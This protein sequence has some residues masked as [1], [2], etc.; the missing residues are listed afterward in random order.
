MEK[1]IIISYATGTGAKPV[2]DFIKDCF[3]VVSG[4]TEDG[5][6]YITLRDRPKE[7]IINEA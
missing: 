2:R 3:E 4:T 1:K 7:D 5:I 6:E